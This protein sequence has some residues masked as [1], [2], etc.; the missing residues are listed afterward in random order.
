MQQEQPK[1]ARP[2]GKPRRTGKARATR[3][4]PV[5]QVDA[6]AQTGPV[7]N[8]KDRAALDARAGIPGL[9]A[10][11]GFHVVLLAIFAVIVVT[12][13]RQEEEDI[14]L[15]GWLTE[16]EQPE[17]VAE[18]STIK[19]ESFEV[20]PQEPKKVEQEPEET[21]EVQPSANPQNTEPVD[22]QQLLDGRSSQL[23]QSLLI[24]SGGDDRTKRAVESGLLW[25]KRQ[26][27][28]S[29]NWQLHTGYPDASYAVLR[30]DTGATALALLV[31]LGAGNTH[32]SGDHA[33]A[34]RRGLDWLIS[35][36]K[37]N[38]DF[39]DHAE[40][41]RQTAF[42]AHAQATI[43]VC[44]AFALTGDENLRVPAERG[45]RWLV[46]SQQPTNG[47]WKYQPQDE[48][49]V[50]DLSVTGWALMA[51][52]TGRVARLQISREPF[53]LASR[54][55]DSVQERN[56]ALYKYEPHGGPGTVS[57]AMTAEGLLCRQFLG[58]PK[59]HPGMVAGTEFLLRE[60]HAPSWEAGR[61]NVYEWYYVGHVLHNLNNERFKEW[62][63][64][65]QKMIVDQQVRSGSTTSG[66]DIRGSWSPNEP[67]GAALEY[68]DRAGRLYFTCMCLLVL[69][70][71]YRHMPIYPE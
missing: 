46:R 2:G 53:D 42:Y 19:L 30:T 62:Y 6:D 54:F 60:E 52:H 64:P 31:L 65:V 71:P 14:L 47:G 5:I 28:P 3:R 59:Q 35:K 34:V 67:R 23:Q 51:L 49:S 12:V 29:G 17:A 7:S 21:P 33:S 44:E 66:K 24:S 36:Q 38:G 15:L 27:R 37:A 41:G 39:H 69:E 45:I 68:A 61:R 58:W 40:L 8:W 56:G 25:L 57:V 10:S 18:Q 9:L 1:P 20:T 43:A 22:V 26:Q 55:L 4:K 50:G 32:K 70:M 13:N 48:N 63:L 11:F 16:S